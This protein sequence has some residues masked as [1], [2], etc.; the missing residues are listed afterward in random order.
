MTAEKP[1]RRVDLA[2]L[3][4]VQEAARPPLPIRRWIVLPAA[5][6][7]AA[8]ATLNLLFENTGASAYL[9]ATQI[10][11]IAFAFLLVLSFVVNPLLRLTRWVKP[12]N[13]AEIMCLFAAL[14]VSAGI[15]S[16]G[17]VDQL[18]PLMSSPH[19]SRWNTPQSGWGRDIIPHLNPHLY[20]TD[21]KVIEA[22]REGFP[23]RGA[24][25]KTLRQ[26]LR[27]HW[28]RVRRIPWWTWGKPLAG[29]MVFVFAVYAMFYG[30]SVLLYETWAQREKLILPLARLPEDMIHDEGAPSGSLPAT[31]RSG[32]FWVGFLFVFSLLGYNGA[33][34]AGWMGKLE[35]LHLGIPVA[36]LERMV[37]NSVFRG[38]AS[39][40]GLHIVI[41][42]T[43]IGIGFLLPLEISF[44]LWIYHLIKL[45]MFLVAIWCAFGASVASFQS[46]WIYQNHFVSAMGG[47]GLLA[48]AAVCLA[49]V[50]VE[51]WSPAVRTCRGGDA[52][53]RVRGALVWGGAAVVAACVAATLVHR[54]HPPS[55]ESLPTWFPPE[56]LL[57]LLPVIAG[58]VFLAAA[59]GE[60]RRFLG[61]LLGRGGVLFTAATVVAV[62][63]LAWSRI[64]LHYGVAFMAVIVLVTIGFMRVVAEGGVFWVQLHVGPFHL[65]KVLHAVKRIPAAVLA[66]LVAIYGVLFLDIKTYI[67]PA[68]LNSFKMAEETRASRRR[69]H[70]TVI[71][72]ILVTVGVSLFVIL[73]LSYRV[74][75]NQMGRWFFTGLP[76][77]VFR[78]AQQLAS[79]KVGTAGEYNWA[80]YLA[81]AGWVVASV[82]LRRRFFWWLHPIGFVMLANPLMARLWFPFFLGW[83]CK[84]LA[85]KYGGRHQFARLRPLFIGL[86]FGELL[87]CFVWA[88]LK[89]VY[90][91]ERV[92]IDINR[93]AP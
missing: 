53:R 1:Y 64:P 10:S 87:A 90:G 50:V 39:G 46:E 13:R 23:E 60:V 18:V 57:F 78:R 31:L 52:W 29:W 68:I 83:V 7:C 92:R 65:A 56:L 73:Y 26:S 2:Q 6:L 42:F 21:P 28:Q 84:K 40:D 93:Y 11:V 75:A 85:V 4:R 17:L 48:F 81:G 59:G 24:P 22:F 19:Y 16:F 47:G 3:E 91:L 63:W 58:V 51:R 55:M 20:I 82:L 37:E 27:R 86:I 35:R 14:F 71:V 80:W 70:A 72:A 8:Q 25:P 33:C 88:V 54:L 79:G 62:G 12:F 43:A 61:A 66:P 89:Q 41:I 9:I 34:Q 36:T 49:K 77:S 5:L 32:A 38:I 15:S 76:Q 67:A 30:L 74:G 45:G 69:F 44:S